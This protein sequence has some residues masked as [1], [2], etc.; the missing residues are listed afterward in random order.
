MSSRFGIS[1]RRSL[2]LAGLATCSAA[3]TGCG[4]L[5]TGNATPTAYYALD[6]QSSGAAQPAPTAA[7]ATLIINSPAAAAGFDSPRMIYQ[8]EPGRLQRFAYSEW[9]DTPARMLWPLLVTAA[10]DSGVY[11]AVAISPGSAYGERR[12]DSEIL[13]LVQEFGPGPS[14]VR[15]TLRVWLI[16]EKSR[17]VL[18]QRD[19]EASAVAASD[20]PAGGARAA[21]EAAATVLRALGRFLQDS[22]AL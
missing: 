12:L 4:V 20:D 9:V 21:N 22:A 11:R 2:L 6:A 14:R 10:R 7:A 15:L 17:R 5:R 19:L 3:L 1:G 8:R 16:E 18:A 13:R